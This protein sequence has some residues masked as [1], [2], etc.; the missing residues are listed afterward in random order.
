MSLKLERRL[1]DEKRAPSIVQARSL[2][3]KIQ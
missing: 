1:G 3:E 2:Y